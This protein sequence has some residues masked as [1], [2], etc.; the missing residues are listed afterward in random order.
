[1]QERERTPRP[2]PSG[3]GLA[4]RVDRAA[5]R[6]AARRHGSFGRLHDGTHPGVPDIG[7]RS[8]EPPPTLRRDDLSDD[9][10]TE[11]RH[12]SCLAALATGVQGMEWGHKWPNSVS[13][14][15]HLEAGVAHGQHFLD[16]G[17]ADRADRTTEQVVA[18]LS[19]EPGGTIPL[20]SQTAAQVE[21]ASTHGG[22]LTS[23]VSARSAPQ[24]ASE[25]CQRC[26][27]SPDRQTR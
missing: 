11:L 1:M 16:I 5:R 22:F 25:A 17:D 9:A 8:P 24:S 21:Q 20:D 4:W 19:L 7:T 23:R 13:S 2:R 6:P 27:S 14:P 26:G 15:P 12:S 18:L 10:T 3:I